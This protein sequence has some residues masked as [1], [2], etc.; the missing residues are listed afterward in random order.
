MKGG[1]HYASN[2]KKLF[3]KRKMVFKLIIKKIKNL[4]RNSKKSF[5]K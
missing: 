3:L 5:K 2:K 1:L 4:K